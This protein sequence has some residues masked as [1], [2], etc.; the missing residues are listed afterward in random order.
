MDIV[1]A[2]VTLD[3]ELSVL[4]MEEQDGIM[5]SVERDIDGNRFFCLSDKAPSQPVKNKC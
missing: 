5:Y 3:W 2:Q 1:R 4:F